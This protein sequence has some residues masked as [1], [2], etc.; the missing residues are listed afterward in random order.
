VLDTLAGAVD[1][2]NKVRQIAWVVHE[3]DLR[4]IHH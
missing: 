1:L 4:R 2:A 3:I